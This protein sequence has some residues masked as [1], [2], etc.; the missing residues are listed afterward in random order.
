MKKSATRYFAL[1]IITIGTLAASCYVPATK[2]LPPTP[3]QPLETRVYASPGTKW[4]DF[5]QLSLDLRERGTPDES[6]NQILEEFLLTEASLLLSKK[7]YSI[8]DSGAQATLRV[9]FGVTEK[10]IESTDTKSVAYSATS[11]YSPYLTSYSLLSGLWRSASVS[12]ATWTTQTEDIYYEAEISVELY[13]KATNKQLWRGDVF[14]PIDSRDIRVGSNFMFRE[15]LWAFPAI[16]Y[17]PTQVLE[18]EDSEFDALWGAYLQDREFYIPG[19]R[20]HISFNFQGRSLSPEAAEQEFRI[21]SDYQKLKNSERPFE[22]LES[23][24]MYR[25]ALQKWY[26]N[27][28]YRFAENR[29]KEI[30]KGS[31]KLLPAYIDALQTSPLAYQDQALNLHLV[32]EYVIGEQSVFVHLVASPIAQRQTYQVGM[33]KYI[34]TKYY[35]SS[36]S[37]CTRDEFQSIRAQAQKQREYALGSIDDLE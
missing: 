29:I 2:V 3:I 12:T 15:L 34:R 20:H 23:T 27:N 35:I 18:A 5:K 36:A 30:F 17:A 10:R 19:V 11:S 22:R 24:K 9:F 37:I 25:D 31:T 28:G 1:A 14:L 21:S 32:G 6:R 4:S 26:D 13:E 8:A 16:G 33:T 7:G